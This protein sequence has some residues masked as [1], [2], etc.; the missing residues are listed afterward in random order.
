MSPAFRLRW[1]RRSG[2]PLSHD[3]AVA[4]RGDLTIAWAGHLHDR[5]ELAARCGL[6]AGADV[7]ALVAA[8]YRRWDTR[9]TAEVIGEYTV[10]LAD[11]ARGRLIVGGDALGLWQSYI[12][13]RSDIVEVVS[14]LA[15]FGDRGLPI[16]KTYFAHYLVTGHLTTALT[17]YEGVARTLP[18]VAEIFGKDSHESLRVWSLAALHKVE[19]IAEAEAAE[20]LR[21]L[22]ARAMRNAVDGQAATLVALSGGLDSS[23]VA[24][25]AAHE[26]LPGLTAY[27]LVHPTTPEFDES[28]WAR[29][30][31]DRY[32]LPWRHIDIE[33]ELPFGAFPDTLTGEPSISLLH[34]PQRLAIARI[35]AEAGA[36][37]VLTGSGGDVVLGTYLGS[38]PTFLTDPLFAGALGETWRQLRAWRRD[39]VVKR[40]LRHWAMGGL[41]RPSLLHLR[42]QRQDTRPVL[43]PPDYMLADDAGA[44]A[45]TPILPRCRSPWL[46][47]IA[48][49][50]QMSAMGIAASRGVGHAFNLRTPLLY[51]PLVKF[52]LTLPVDYLYR[53]KADRYIQRIA[54]KGILPEK[55][56]RR[57]GKTSGSW[58]LIEGLRR[59][60]EWSDFLCDRSLLADMGLIDLPKW[61]QA[62]A[63]A[64]HGNT[65]GDMYLMAT[66]SA[67]AWL[68]MR[69]A[70]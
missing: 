63:M 10:A 66:A 58:S 16:C 68:R 4:V 21:E 65:Q 46:Q 31:V 14:D 39:C 9:F 18:G 36:D 61:R 70:S 62:V 17:P 45:S 24:A 23:T 13:E 56:R 49:L 20:R 32:G 3:G 22:L 25:V 57:A 54:L 35:G 33:R 48:E 29:A 51:L 50:L 27:T 42:G 67:E 52:L 41:V 28:A 69:E 53:S 38:Y 47:M 6:D 60:D 2:Q 19:P 37:T 43:P 11:L 30:V 15:L 7:P 59:S 1:D 8:A 44:S 64:R 5:D 34:Q 12:H 40:S 55:V 26:G